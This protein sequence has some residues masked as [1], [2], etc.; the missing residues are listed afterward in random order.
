M[1]CPWGNGAISD[2]CVSKFPCCTEELP[3]K[4]SP[5]PVWGTA[6]EEGVW[7]QDANAVQGTDGEQFWP[8]LK[9]T[10]K[11]IIFNDLAMRAI[12]FEN[13]KDSDGNPETTTVT[14]ANGNE[15]T[16][17]RFTPTIDFWQNADERPQ[18]ARYYRW[19]PSGIVN[20]THLHEG[21]PVFVSAPHFL[22]GD[23]ILLDMVD[24]LSPDPAKHRLLLD[25]EPNTGHTFQEHSRV[26]INT[27]VQ[28]KKS[29][30]SIIP[31]P[32][33]SFDYFSKIQDNTYV[34]M[35]WFELI[36]V[37]KPVDADPMEDIYMG[38]KVETGTL[39]GGIAGSVVF[40]VSLIFMIFRYKSMTA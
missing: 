15:I 25:I 33:L 22:H 32:C 8:D 36:G 14:D 23:E 37:I 39:Y 19:G 10:D 5:V 27:L 20:M 2:Y 1:I 6:F 29:E 11:I 24:G 38:A 35:A 30:G 18:N 28:K 7:D 31:V 17:L 12:Q 3:S 16:L 26:Q 40:S 9:D 34:P 21:A 4:H 13:Q